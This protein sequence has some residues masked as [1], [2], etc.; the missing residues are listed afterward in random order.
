MTTLR[1]V[2][3]MNTGRDG[4]RFCADNDGHR[5]RTLLRHLPPAA[6][7]GHGASSSNHDRHRLDRLDQHH[8]AGVRR[9]QDIPPLPRRLPDGPADD[10]QTCMGVSPSGVLCS[11]SQL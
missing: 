11:S 10:V 6:L 1:N 5:R 8:H 7:Q 3:D 2:R 4:V 9:S